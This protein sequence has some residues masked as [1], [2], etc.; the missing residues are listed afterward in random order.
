MI[1]TPYQARIIL[2]WAITLPEW[3]AD[4]APEYAPHPLL[5]QDADEAQP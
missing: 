1:V 5:V 3:D 4:D 2:A